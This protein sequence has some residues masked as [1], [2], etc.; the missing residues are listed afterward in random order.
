MRLRKVGVSVRRALDFVTP[1]LVTSAVLALAGCANVAYYAQSVTGHLALISRARP[2][3]T[4][5]AAPETAP[6]LAAR[7]RTAL[8]IRDFASTALSLP[9]NDSYRRYVDLGRPTRSGTSWR[10]RSFRS[11]R[12]SGASPWPAA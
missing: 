4:V 3:E 12:G 10:R 6:R 1:W 2:M 11:S 5:L 7:L 8:D 9:A